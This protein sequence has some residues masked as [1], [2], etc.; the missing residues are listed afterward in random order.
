LFELGDEIL[1]ARNASDVLEILQDVPE[2]VAR[3]IGGRARE[4][5]LGHHTSS[6]RAAELEAIIDAAQRPTVAARNPATV[7]MQKEEAVL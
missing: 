6:H 1:V 4:R 5:V 3:E 2:S 7:N